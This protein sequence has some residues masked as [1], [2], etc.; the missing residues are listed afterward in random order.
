MDDVMGMKDANVTVQSEDDDE[1]L[2]IR[3]EQCGSLLAHGH[4]HVTAEKPPPPKPKPRA[5]ARRKVEPKML[6]YRA[7]RAA[8]HVAMYSQIPGVSKVRATVLQKE[9]PTFT[10]LMEASVD[11]IVYLFNER[12][13]LAKAEEIA[14]AIYRTFH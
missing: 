10:A 2:V 13:G 11:D 3:C 5:P 12:T 9:Y 14:E 4:E 8:L 7:N 6:R 1:T